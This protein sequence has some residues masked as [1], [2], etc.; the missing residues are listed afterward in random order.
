MIK[1]TSLEVFT[2]FRIP[3]GLIMSAVTVYGY[4]TT[5]TYGI[6]KGNV[7]GS[8]I[9][10]IDT[11]TPVGTTTTLLSTSCSA[12]EYIV[13]KWNAGSVYNPITAPLASRLFGASITLK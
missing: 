3:A 2:M 6:Y 9:T 5:D 12:G 10:N 8:T 11:S 1:S 4:P 7:T 13:L